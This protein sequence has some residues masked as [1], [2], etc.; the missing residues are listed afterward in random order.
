MDSTSFRNEFVTNLLLVFPVQHEINK[1]Q[2]SNV[3]HYNICI[4]LFS[5]E[6][7]F[8]YYQVYDWASNE[9]DD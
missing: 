2:I 6:Y 7:Y 1:D 3:I 8:F 9:N 5:Q 4:L